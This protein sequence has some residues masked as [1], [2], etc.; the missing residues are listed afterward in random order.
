[1]KVEGDNKADF[2]NDDSGL[3][4]VRMS[5]YAYSQY[6]I[7][8]YLSVYFGGIGIGSSVIGSE[9][10]FFYADDATMPERSE[11]LWTITNVSTI[12]F[13]KISF[14]INLFSFL[15]CDQPHP[16]YQMEKSKACL[17]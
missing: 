7:A 17:Y 12:F 8:E 14:P 5:N 2:D 4:D 3:E 15:N 13:S 16:L 6:K 10:L 1:M 9:L 11:V